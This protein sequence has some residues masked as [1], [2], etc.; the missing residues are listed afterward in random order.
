MEIKV[1][2][3]RILGIDAGYDYADELSRRLLL[4]FHE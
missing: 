2:E 3:K 4:K 1:R